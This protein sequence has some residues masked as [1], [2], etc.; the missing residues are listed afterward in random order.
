[1]SGS[2][3]PALLI[4]CLIL[5]GSAL[6][7]PAAAQTTANIGVVSNYLWRGVTQTDDGPAVQGG[8]DYSSKGGFVAGAWLSNVRFLGLEETTVLQPGPE[9]P[10]EAVLTTETTL[11]PTVE[12]DLYSGYGGSAGNFSYKGLFTYYLYPSGGDFDLLEFGASGSYEARSASLGLSLN[13]ALWGEAGGDLPFH[14]GDFYGQA[15]VRFSLPEG[16]GI[17]ALYG[18]YS[19]HDAGIAYPWA[20][21]AVTSDAGDWG[22]FGVNVSRAWGDVEDLTISGG[23]DTKV[24]VSWVKLF[25]TSVKH[26]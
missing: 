5:P 7:S 12:I 23:R 9:G 3:R 14:A 1:M 17:G 11:D 26:E 15:N 21:L 18:Y 24:W 6:V 25:E 20:G 13:Y 22:T 4:V 8:I 10:V 19:F 16:F 2:R